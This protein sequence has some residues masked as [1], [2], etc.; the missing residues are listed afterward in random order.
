M[1]SNLLVEIV[2]Y[3]F[4]LFHSALDYDMFKFIIYSMKCLNRHRSGGND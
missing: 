1:V 2:I 3:N 4:D